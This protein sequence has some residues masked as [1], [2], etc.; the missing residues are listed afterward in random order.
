MLQQKY[1]LR[2]HIEFVIHSRQDYESTKL[3]RFTPVE[4][5]SGAAGDLNY[6]FE[7]GI[8][9]ISIYVTGKK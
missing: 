6:T 9:T 5:V 3:I 4:L 8:T 1:N 7:V 2:T